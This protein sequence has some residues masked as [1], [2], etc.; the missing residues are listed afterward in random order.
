MG[1]GQMLGRMAKQVDRRF[2]IR[3]WLRGE[4]RP[5]AGG[6]DLEGEKLI[7]WG[8]I[9][10]NLPRRKRKALEIGPGK[11]PVIPAML[12]L[13]Y[14]VTAID[15]W[16]DPSAI[17]EG[18]NFINRDFN[19]V[20]LAGRFDVIVLCSVVEHIGLGGRF[21]SN[22][23]PDGDLKAMERVSPLLSD[24]GEFF[25]TIPVGQDAVYRPWHRVYGG[26]RL[27]LLLLGFEAIQARFLVKDHGGPWRVCSEAEALAS[28]ADIRRYGLGE[29][30][31][32]KARSLGVDGEKVR[33]R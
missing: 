25:L 15:P 22:E 12:A 19:T 5:P 17:I 7:D 11:S 23:D 18:I 3:E 32:R 29:M 4:P 24:D 10:A 2:G 13:G 1:T 8:W 27:P 31:L 6:F 16:E 14:E 30:I 9:C 26:E 20:S 21:N 33:S 28:P